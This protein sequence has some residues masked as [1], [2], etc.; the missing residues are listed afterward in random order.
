LHPLKTNTFYAAQ[1]GF[2]LPGG[3]PERRWSSGRRG[4]RSRALL[5]ASSVNHFATPEIW[6]NHRCLPAETRELA[7]WR[8]AMLQ[9]DPRKPALRLRRVGEFCSAR[10]GPRIRAL[11]RNRPEGLVWTWI[12]PHDRYEQLIA[13]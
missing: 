8:F 2:R 5:A 7:D 3:P 10:V 9:A 12:G 4:V 11:A 13:Q 6:F 1:P